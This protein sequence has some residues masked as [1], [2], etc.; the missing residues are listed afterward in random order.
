MSRGE[1]SPEDLE[2]IA[3]QLPEIDD[4]QTLVPGMAPD[5]IAAVF[6][7]GSSVPFAAPCLHDTLS[8]V[9]EARYSLH[10]VLAH[11]RWYLEASG[12]PRPREAAFFARFYLDDIALRL[13][14]AGERLAD[15]IIFM[16]ALDPTQ[17]QAHQGSHVSRQSAVGHYLLNA[18]PSHEVT[19]FLRELTQNSTW[20]AAIEYR[21]VWVHQQPPLVGELG[22]AYRRGTRWQLDPQSGEYQLQL[23]SGDPPHY[24]IGQI[25]DMIDPALRAFVICFRHVV[26]HYRAL[27]ENHGIQISGNTTSISG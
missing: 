4:L 1:L 27:L 5:M 17:L 24:T 8:A 10:E 16:L 18:L 21:N 20:T 19:G 23:V 15:A 11:N 9:E 6:E 3:G 7:H 14:A 22:L 2:S 25:Y 12:T 13:Y 26:D